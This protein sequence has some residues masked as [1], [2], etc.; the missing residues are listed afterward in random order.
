MNKEL[1]RKNALDTRNAL[2][3]AEIVAKSRAVFEKLKGTD[4]YKDA[5]N[6]LVYASFGSEV[7]TDDIISESLSLGKNVFCPKVTDPKSGIMEF[8]RID[9]IKDLREGYFHIMEPQ[10]TDRSTLYS[11]QD[12][13]RTLLIVPL[14]AFDRNMNRIGYGGGFY[15]RYLSRYPG[16]VT[17]SAAFECQMADEDIESEQGDIK[18]MM[19][20]TESRMYKNGGSY[21]KQKYQ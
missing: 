16:A 10:I 3:E 12:P 13:D 2:P 7:S 9:H 17:I 8:V 4:A 19:I 5:V 20:I 11:G 21:E 14:V 6:I 1:L 15:D 18:P